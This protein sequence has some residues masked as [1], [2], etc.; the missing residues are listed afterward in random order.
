MTLFINV[1][2][3][4]SLFLVQPLTMSKVEVF[5]GRADGQSGGHIKDS[6]KL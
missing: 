5:L 4:I 3:I 2:I 1:L 6:F